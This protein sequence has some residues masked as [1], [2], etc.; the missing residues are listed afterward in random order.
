ME[1]Q[2]KAQP[3]V[4]KTCKVCKAGKLFSEF[5]KSGSNTYKTACKP[6]ANA[7]L[8]KRYAD[9]NDNF[10]TSHLTSR[11]SSHYK[12]PRSVARKLAEDRNGVCQICKTTQYLVVD[13]CHTTNKYRDVICQSCN[14]MLGTAKDNIETLQ[15]AI[16]YLIA[17]GAE[18]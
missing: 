12:M 15:S 7:K 10:R 17:H 9:P 6:C 4:I 2:A 16:Q 11:L 13:H 8:R 5:H 3:N 18:C 1:V 14:V